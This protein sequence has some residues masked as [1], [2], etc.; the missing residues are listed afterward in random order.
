[1]PVTPHAGQAHNYHLTM[2]NR[3]C[4]MSEYFPV[5]DVEIG[6]ELFYY[7]SDGDPPPRV[8]V[9]WICRRTHQGW[10]LS[11]PTSTSG[12]STFR[13]NPPASMMV[14]IFRQANQ[15]V[16]IAPYR[17]RNNDDRSAL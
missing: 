3:N 14:M 1:V 10:V 15:G 5:H 6:N 12:I 2:A 9:S 8:M 11:F 7:I 13:R 17:G 4:P 16:T